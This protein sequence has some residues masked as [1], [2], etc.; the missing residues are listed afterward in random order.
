MINK[1][2]LS[3]YFRQNGPENPTTVKVQIQTPVTAPVQTP[4]EIQVQPPTPVKTLAQAPVLVHNKTSTTPV[5]IPVKTSA[6]IQIPIRTNIPI[7]TPVTPANIP[8]PPAR[9][10][11]INTM[12]NLSPIT[13]AYNNAL[14]QITQVDIFI[15]K[16]SLHIQ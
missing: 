1:S 13:N 10:Q 3:I 8:E 12:K 14:I 2:W 7:Q 15:L 9:Q 11:S 5:Q 16:L 6:P 4:V